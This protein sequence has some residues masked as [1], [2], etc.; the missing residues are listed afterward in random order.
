M[1]HE[2]GPRAWATIGDDMALRLA[3]LIRIR[4]CGET[5]EAN[6]TRMAGRCHVATQLG[7]AGGT[8]KET[9]VS[10]SGQRGGR[11]LQNRFSQP[12]V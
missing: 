12:V 6:P 7:W 11:F 4:R 10:D 3:K 5:F 8:G 9:I 2:Q 1:G